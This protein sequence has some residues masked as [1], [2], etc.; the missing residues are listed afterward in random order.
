[1]I[2]GNSFVYQDD[3]KELIQQGRPYGSMETTPR[4]AYFTGTLVTQAT[5]CVE[6]LMGSFVC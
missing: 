5:Q 3:F 6:R 2:I 1:M 4:G